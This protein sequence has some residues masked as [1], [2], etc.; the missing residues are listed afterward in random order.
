M[1]DNV[2]FFMVYLAYVR[3]FYDNNRSYLIYVEFISYGLNEQPRT[4]I[5]V[6]KYNREKIINARVPSGSLGE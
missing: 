3:S 2:L 5:S 4:L 1:Y 6:L